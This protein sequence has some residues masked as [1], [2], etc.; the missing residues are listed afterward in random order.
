MTT[1]TYILH[2]GPSY[3][4]FRFIV[5]PLG[6]LCYRTSQ[7]F[8]GSMEQILQGASHQTIQEYWNDKVAKGWNRIQ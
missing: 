2:K 4:N 7:K 1:K 5:N 3:Y 8:E 6:M